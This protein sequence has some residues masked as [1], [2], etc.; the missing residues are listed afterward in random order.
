[1]V[2]FQM[3][4]SPHGLG[5]ASVQ[6]M[7]SLQRVLVTNEFATDA[8]DPF[9]TI[10]ECSTRRYLDNFLTNPYIFLAY[11]GDSGPESPEYAKKV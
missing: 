3:N 5:L 6:D 8:I 1:M 7:L 11:S 10:M 2:Q 4:F 9:G